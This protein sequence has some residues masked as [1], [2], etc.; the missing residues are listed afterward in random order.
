MYLEFLS[1]VGYHP[2]WSKYIS[3]FVGVLKSYTLYLLVYGFF[4]ITFGLAFF[5]MFPKSD[6][7][8]ETFDLMIL[9]MLAMLLGE[10]DLMGTPFTSDTHTRWMEIIFFTL[11]LILIILVLQN[12]LNALAIKDT[13]EMLDASDTDTLLIILD[14]VKFWAFFLAKFN[15]FLSALNINIPLPNTLSAFPGKK[16]YFPVFHPEFRNENS[17]PSLQEGAVE[18]K[19]KGE[20]SFKQIL[21]TRPIDKRIA[22]SAKEIIAEGR[23]SDQSETIED[24]VKVNRT[25]NYLR[26]GDT[27]TQYIMYY[28]SFAES[29]E[30]VIRW[31]GET[32]EIKTEGK[33]IDNNVMIFLSYVS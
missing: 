28:V 14:L 24:I 27:S 5:Q 19:V 29:V 13:S 30:R 11:F 1:E 2:Y 31:N 6:D 23:K 4:L 32:L 15:T 16:I 8:P 21:K 9:K 25:Y 20:Y 7:F 12:L 26:M 33:Q 3:M 17:F 10:I 18:Y 22:E